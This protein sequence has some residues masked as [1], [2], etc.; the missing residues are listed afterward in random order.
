MCSER[1]Q[2]EKGWDPQCTM[3]D[4]TTRCALAVCFVFLWLALVCYS[5]LSRMEGCDVIFLGY[6]CAS[7]QQGLTQIL[8]LHEQS[9]LMSAWTMSVS[10]LTWAY[11]KPEYGQQCKC[12]KK[13]NIL[14]C[15]CTP[16]SQYC[17]SLSAAYLN[18][19][20]QVLI[21]LYKRKKKC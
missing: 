18:G 13:K 7:L 10:A 16:W 6:K 11:R 1:W 20:I 15:N 21:L 9:C 4:V 14:S 8:V 2:S 5:L 12:L 19:A 17:S 3:G